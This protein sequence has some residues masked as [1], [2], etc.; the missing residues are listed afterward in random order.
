MPRKIEDSI[1]SSKDINII[2]NDFLSDVKGEQLVS[3]TMFSSIFLSS[4]RVPAAI[5]E[6]LADKDF[7]E[8]TLTG[9]VPIA[10]TEITRP[11]W[12]EEDRGYS[13]MLVD[14]YGSVCLASDR[15]LLDVIIA[16]GNMILDASKFTLREAAEGVGLK[17]IAW[18]YVNQDLI[19]A[20]LLNRGVYMHISFKDIATNLKIQNLKKNRDRILEQLRRLSIMRLEITPIHKDGPRKISSN[21]FSFSLIDK[22]Y[23][24]L[25][26][27]SKVR[28]NKYNEDTVTDLLV[29]V[30]SYYIKS[31]GKD[32]TIS[33][34]RLKNHYK[35][36]VGPYNIEDFYKFLDSNARKFINNKYLSNLAKTY[37]DQKI[38]HF[39]VNR[40]YK[41]RKLA[42]Q[43]IDDEAKLFTHFNFR[44]KPVRNKKSE[45]VDYQFIY[46]ADESKE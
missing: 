26:D 19:D 21:G 16:S 10:S 43:V 36:L 29:S 14:V 11:Y 23:F 46:I 22:D 41:L 24:C 45:V 35:H 1:E 13:A 42:E 25:L 7:A 39:G 12:K 30:S 6:K 37:F 4:N 38:G 20:P 9:K 27:R 33:R 8:D 44:L 40:S 3:S 32:G 18:E 5:L 34:R 15:H 2:T 17:D 31:L 28:N